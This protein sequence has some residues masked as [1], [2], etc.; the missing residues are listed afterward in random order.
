VHVIPTILD[1]DIGTDIDDTW[2]LAMLSNTPELDLRLVTTATGD[3]TYRARIAAGILA[4][5]GRS[6][7]PIGIGVE[8]D[9]RDDFPSKFQRPQS[10]YAETIDLGSH[11]GGVVSDGVGALIECIMQSPD[12]VTVITIGPL[13]NIAAALEREPAIAQ[14]ARVVGML[15]SVRNAGPFGDDPASEYNVGFDVPACRAVFEAPW[16]V[17]ITPLDTCGWITLEGDAH[18]SIR[19]SEDRLLSDVMLNYSVWSDAIEHADFEEKSTT[20]FDTVAVYL[21]YDEELLEMIVGYGRP[22]R[23]A[24]SWRDQQAFGAHLLK[25]LLSYTATARA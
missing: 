25:R 17:T 22:V 1:T 21:A 15:G 8:T 7:V 16:D 6:E 18:R 4:A 14:R 23:V 20:L 3:T 11:E 12:P 13:T 24:T 2:A 9:F 19:A 10:R 5:G